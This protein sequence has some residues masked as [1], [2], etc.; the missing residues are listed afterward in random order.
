MAEGG[1]QEDKTEEASA[2]KLQQ[3][4]EKGDVA[5][6]ADL[7]QAMSLIGAVGVLAFAGPS[8]CMDLARDLTPFIA[9]PEQLLNSMDGDGGMAIFRHLLMSVLPVLI[10]VM[11]GALFLGVAGNVMQT[12]FMFTPSK[13]KPNFSILN[14]MSG[15]AKLFGPDALIT[16]GKTLLKL[17]ITGVIVWNVL[18]DRLNG[19]VSLT[20]VSPALILP[21]CR[22]I[23]LVLAISVCI[24]LFVGG[25]ADYMLQRFRFMQKMKMSKEEQKEE[26][27]Q[28]E[29][30]PHVKAKLRQLRMEKG[31]RRMMANVATATVVVTN[32]THYAVALRYEAGETAAP[33]CV[34]KGVDAVAL[35][36]REEAGKH[37]VPIVEDPPLARALYAAIDIDEVIPEEHFAAVAKLISFVL[38]RKRRGF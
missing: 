34:A 29:G 27:K 15:L 16:F 9:H 25:G 26:Y 13:L 37:E 23:L 24:F 4:R 20:H 11:S 6:S 5:K 31:R 18:K 1:D 14:P 10:L 8:I 22:D 2:R 30:D 7:P 12:G 35:K 17:I 32:P 28:T 38:T 36:I 33:I 19:I 21:Y 3:A